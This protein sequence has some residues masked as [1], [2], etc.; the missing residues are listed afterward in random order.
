MNK[1][2]IAAAVLAAL[3]PAAQATERG[4]VRALNGAAG[5][6]VSSAQFPGWYGQAWVQRYTA[7]D[8]KDG[9]GNA[10]VTNVNTPVGPVAVERGGKV[11]ATV[12][13]L[14][15]TWLSEIRLGEGKFG[16]SATLPLVSLTQ[17]VTATPRF[18]AGTP[19]LVVAG[20]TAQANAA[21]AAASGSRSGVGD[22]ELMPYVDW[23]TDSYR[24]AFGLGLT[25]PTGDYSAARAVNPGAGK[26]WTLRP[27]AVGSYAFD[28]GLEV[29]ARATYSFNGKNDATGNRSG[30]YLAADVSSH[31]RLND[32]WKLGVQG[33][34]NWQTTADR[35]ADPVASLCGKVRVFGLGPSL[36]YLSEDGRLFVDAKWLREVGVRNRPQGN[37]FWL[38]A[39]IRLDE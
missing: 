24:Y 18:A 8:F 25:A 33:F 16:F 28:N 7:S 32:F 14:R 23:Q 10:P 20:V 37:V 3:L 19:A 34:V 12:A 17:T 11:E 39:N 27:L 9:A 35:C 26:F 36:N 5:A 22:V 38:R 6:E 2:L 13:V 4:A 29:G 15:A 21:A 30:Q 1:T 31:Y